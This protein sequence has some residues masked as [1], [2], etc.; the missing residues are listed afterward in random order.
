MTSTP[1][2]LVD[3]RRGL[4]LLDGRGMKNFRRR[5][6]RIY[7]FLGWQLCKYDFLLSERLSQ[8]VLENYFGTV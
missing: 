7:L 5:I 8:D 2:S 4:I 6:S 1:K 3:C